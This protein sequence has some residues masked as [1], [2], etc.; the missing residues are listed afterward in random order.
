M[1]LP[2]LV[3]NPQLKQL[4]EQDPHLSRVMELGKKATVALFTI[5]AFGERSALVREGFLSETLMRDLQQQGAVGDICTHV[6]NGAGEICN[7]GL[8][9]RT[10]A[11]SLDNIRDMRYRIGV[12]QGISKVEAIKGALQSGIMNVFITNEFTAERVLK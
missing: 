5:G 2:A 7:P 12:A 4:L 8:E 10:M 6:I 1:Q 9:E 3:E 11:I